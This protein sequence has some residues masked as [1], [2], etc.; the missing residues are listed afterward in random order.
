MWGRGVK[1]QRKT[2]KF[3]KKEKEKSCKRGSLLS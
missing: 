1:N 2:E 3:L